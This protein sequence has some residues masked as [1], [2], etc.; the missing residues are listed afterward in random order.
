MAA[1]CACSATSRG[2]SA[3]NP[4]RIGSPAFVFLVSTVV[5]VLFFF[6]VVTICDLVLPALNLEICRSL[7]LS[8]FLTTLLHLIC[9]FTNALAAFVAYFAAVFFFSPICHLQTSIGSELSQYQAGT[10]YNNLLFL[11]LSGSLAKT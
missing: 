4:C 7:S 5:T 2:E 9:L 11:G 8:S 6:F 10:V 1:M 3:A